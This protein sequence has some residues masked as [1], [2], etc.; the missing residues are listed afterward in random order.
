MSYAR[1]QVADAVVETRASSRRV[2]PVTGIAYYTNP[3]SVA[4]R[5]RLIQCPHDQPEKVR[6]RVALFGENIQQVADSWKRVFSSVLAD[7]QPEDVAAG[8]LERVSNPLQ[9]EIAQDPNS[10]L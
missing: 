5:Q 9:S 1:L 2:D 7:G 4:I 6:V 3:N 10:G 8:V